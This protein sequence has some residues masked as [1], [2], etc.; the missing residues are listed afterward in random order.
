[1]PDHVHLMIEVG[2]EEQ[3]GVFLRDFKKHTSRKIGK[4]VRLHDSHLWQRGSM[5]HRIRT[6]W[7]NSDFTKHFHY[8]FYNSQ[9]HLSVAPKDFPYHNFLEQVENGRLDMDFC[10]FDEEKYSEYAMYEY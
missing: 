5:D 8:L 2:R 1:M 4:I 3:T 9:K 10:A 6:T 7:A